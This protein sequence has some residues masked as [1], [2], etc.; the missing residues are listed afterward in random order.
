[1]KGNKL[2]PSKTARAG[3][4]PDEVHFSK[5]ILKEDIRAVLVPEIGFTAHG[6]G[7]IPPCPSHVA[8][9]AGGKKILRIFPAETYK[10]MWLEHR[11]LTIQIAIKMVE[12]ITQKKETDLSPPLPILPPRPGLNDLAAR[13][14]MVPLKNGHGVGFIGRTTRSLSCV[15][16]DQLKYYFSGLSN[17][18]KF[19]ISFEHSISVKGVPSGT[20]TCEKTVEGLKKQIEEVKR[21]LE[22]K[23]DD[24][25]SPSTRDIRAFLLSLLI[26]EK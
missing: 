16:P 10:N 1:V 4:F 21:A 26:Q 14:E 9:V 19:V 23:K 3:I 18:G 12:R 13:I 17:H 25:F 20:W 8:L 22:N 15:S 6:Q 24:D 7:K 5:D 2:L 11:D